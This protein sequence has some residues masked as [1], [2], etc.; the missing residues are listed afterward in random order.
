VEKLA[1]DPSA[2][3]PTTILRITLDP[4]TAEQPADHVVVL[5]ARLGAIDVLDTPQPR[6]DAPTWLPLPKPA[7]PRPVLIPARRSGLRLV[8]AAPRAAGSAELAPDHVLLD[9]T[10]IEN[11][12][13][14]SAVD[15]LG[16][17]GSPSLEAERQPDG[18]HRL[19]VDGD[20]EWKVRARIGGR[21]R[22]VA[23]RG[24]EPVPVSAGELHVELSPRGY[25]RLRRGGPE[26]TI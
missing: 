22:D 21:W 8:T 11:G 18:R 16:L 2:G 1:S 25:V 9:V 24:P 7:T 10:S 23:W 17:H 15:A 19:T 26:P 3:H 13:E 14:V 4:A 6:A 20:G 12:D 5:R